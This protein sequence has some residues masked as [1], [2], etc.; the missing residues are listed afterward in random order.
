[1]LIYVFYTDELG[2]KNEKKLINNDTKNQL[3]LLRWV[4]LTRLF[5]LKVS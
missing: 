5:N 2:N 4:T 1:M 3:C